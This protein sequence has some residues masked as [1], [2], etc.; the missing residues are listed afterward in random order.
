[1]ARRYDPEATR[2]D[3]LTAAEQIFAEKGFARASTQEVAA[4]AGV[5]QSQIH[6]HFGSKEALWEAT[7][8]RVFRAYY[9]VQVEILTGALQPGEDRLS[10][11]VEAYFRF[12][13]THPRFARMLMH[14]LLEGGTLGGDPGE[15]LSRMGAGVVRAEQ[16]AGT[17]RGD[18]E[19]S[20]VVLSFLGL[21]SFWFMGSEGLLPKFGLPGSPESWDEIYLDTIQ[22]I[23]RGGVAPQREDVHQTDSARESGGSDP[24]SG[25]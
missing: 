8:E 15:H 10:R 3:I 18:V 19:P 7:H 17:L 9:Q 24:E 20:F 13:Q 2:A 14:N 21:V 1:M 22:K 6:Y 4:A 25:R 23:L 16:E 5:S 11:S 12:F